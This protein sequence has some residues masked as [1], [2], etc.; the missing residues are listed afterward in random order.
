MRLEEVFTPNSA[1][2]HTYVTRGE[3]KLEAQLEG[4]LKVKNT[5]ISISGPSKTGKTALVSK[6]ID[7]NNIIKI[8]GIEIQK[9]GDLWRRVLS[10]M[11][12]PTQKTSASHTEAGI[13]FFGFGAKHA[14][15]S[16]T[17]IASDGLARVCAEIAHSDYVIFI[18]DFHY[19][20]KEIQQFVAREIKAGLEFGLKICVASV[21]HRSDDVVRSNHELAGRAS[22]IDTDYWSINDLYQIGTLGFNS[23]NLKVDDQTI[24]TIAEKCFGSPQLMQTL[25]LNACIVKGVSGRQLGKRPISFSNPDIQEALKRSSST[26]NFKTLVQKLHQGPRSRGVERKEFDF[27]DGSRGDVY[28][29]VL[30]AISLDPGVLEMNYKE[31]TDRVSIVCSKDKQPIGSSMNEALKQ[32]NNISKETLGPD[33]LEWDED[34]LSIMDPYFVFYIKYSQILQELA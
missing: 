15:E 23:L 11:E 14:V 34:R 26:T 3:Q 31:M 8:S 21:P 20:S 5:L 6:V 17:T 12:T 24:L 25:C 13:K 1:P 30:L 2:T 33:I 16:S 18:D 22:C 27:Y 32:M 29:A 7:H 9:E 4:A 19:I 28:R 10:W